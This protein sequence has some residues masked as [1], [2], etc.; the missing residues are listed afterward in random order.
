MH[1]D[2]YTFKDGSPRYGVRTDNTAVVA[3]E[4]RLPQALGRAVAQAELMDNVHLDFIGR[5]PQAPDEA[6]EFKEMRVEH[7]VE[8]KEAEAYVKSK[9][10]SPG[11]WLHS[12]QERG[13]SHFTRTADA[14]DAVRRLG[15]S[16]VALL[17]V[18]VP[19]A[20]AFII[21]VDTRDILS[22]A[23]A[24]FIATAVLLP[25]IKVARR[26]MA[27]DGLYSKRLTRNEMDW[28]WDD[29]VRATFSELLADRRADVSPGLLRAA[30]AAW[31]NHVHVAAKVDEIRQGPSA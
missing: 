8:M 28:I 19:V 7:P 2:M 18:L 16:L 29:L 4:T 1:S 30:S 5:F 20:A 12:A 27:R 15:L 24:Y 10:L 22:A 17:S 26:E 3:E 14:S 21:L 11:K 6:N 31:A 13:D 25:V 9:L 23:G